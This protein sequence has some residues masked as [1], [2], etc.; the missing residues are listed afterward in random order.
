M[1]FVFMHL[2]RLSQSWLTINCRLTRWLWSTIMRLR[3]F[4]WGYQ[5][6]RRSGV[7]S[8]RKPTR[9]WSEIMNFW[10]EAFSDPQFK[11]WS[12]PLSKTYSTKMWPRRKC[13]YYLQK[14]NRGETWSLREVSLVLAT[15][16]KPTLRVFP[17]HMPFQSWE[18]WLFQMGLIWSFCEILGASRNS[19]A[20]GATLITNPGQTSWEKRQKL[21]LKSGKMTA[22]SS[23][24][25][26]ITWK[27]WR[28][29]HLAWTFLRSI[30]HT[31]WHS[32]RPLTTH[33]PIKE[34][35]MIRTNLK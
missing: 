25:S 1:Q 27:T 28:S 11:T 7:L 15:T 20:L 17:T 18:P 5:K 32:T 21:R 13:G 26:K 6:I 24:R 4:I 35:N 2:V 3:P 31:L 16:K 19:M 30:S 22:N 12:G 8:W 34:P 33:S 14:P 10:M 9:N 23:C 29:Q